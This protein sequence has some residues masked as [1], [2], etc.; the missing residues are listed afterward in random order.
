M[1]RRSI[2]ALILSAA[3]FG[4]VGSSASA[5]TIPVPAPAPLAIKPAIPNVVNPVP[6]GDVRLTGGPLKAAQDA[7]QKTLLGLEPDRMLF[8]LR[9]R[10]GLQPKAAR[11]YD[12]WDGAGRNLTGH[13]AGHY[14]SAISYMFASTGDKQYKDR[15]DYMVHELKEIQDAQ[16]D[17][18]IGGL[19]GNAPPAPATAPAS[20]TAAAT[21]AGRRG[22][23][24]G[25]QLPP[26][27]GKI[28]FEEI[29][30]GQIRSG[31]FD[32]NGMW[33]PWY[34]EHK[35]FAGLRDAY[36]LTGNKEA[37]QVETRFAAWVDSIM[38][39]LTQEQLQGY[40]PEG[41]RRIAG[42]LDTEFGGINETLADLYADTGDRHWY[43]LS[44]KFEHLR[45]I[46]PL[47]NKQDI[48]G[49]LHGNTTIPKLYGELKRY[50]YTGDERDGNAARFF[51]D[52]TVFHHTF[53]TGGHG[54]D[55]SFGP[56]DKLSQQVDGTG[57]RS[58]DLRTCES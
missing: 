47:A 33:S 29:A 12:G 57:Q 25:A 48:L 19:M 39:K 40:T 5:E 24:R 58:Q 36:R 13:I 7:D 22:G 53:A 26:V 9:Q 46:T 20:T 41:G 28:L 14:L 6:L 30:A 15:V 17:G 45:V 49:G 52:A 1:V 8:F 55:E 2:L 35:L 16:K 56:A 3:A 50:I 21:G 32:L 54:Y 42:V 38:G 4:A 37:L 27:D 51:W 31:G 43:D 11:G 23:A 34:V 18:Y 10:A 44:S